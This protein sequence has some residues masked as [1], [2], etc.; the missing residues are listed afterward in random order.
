VDFYLFDFQRYWINLSKNSRKTK[1]QA[2]GWHG[3]ERIPQT[4]DE[5]AEILT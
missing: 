5:A 2:A 4:L 3:A 1:S